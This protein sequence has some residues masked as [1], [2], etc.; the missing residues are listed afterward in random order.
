MP[1]L[2]ADNEWSCTSCTMLNPMAAIKCSVCGKSNSHANGGGLKGGK[3]HPL[4]DSDSKDS[5]GKKHK[6]DGSALLPW[7]CP[8]CTLHNLATASICATCNGP[9]P[10]RPSNA[11]V[12]AASG[13]L[14]PPPP[15][16]PWTCSSCT[17]VNFEA[18]ATTC[19]VCGTARD[20]SAATSTAA[21]SATDA[22]VFHPA[23][24]GA[25]VTSAKPQAVI[26]PPAQNPAHS[27]QV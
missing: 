25:G 10:S 9:R 8:L 26:P 27:S 4:D 1:V 7:D 13:G 19:S 12:A 2:V 3:S 18:A 6:A 11:N 15:P 23:A 5:A 14:P 17:V 24:A 22:A 21:P 16:R 20:A